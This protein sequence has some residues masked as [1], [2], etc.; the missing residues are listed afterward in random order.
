MNMSFWTTCFDE[1][2]E[3]M[4]M[5]DCIPYNIYAEDDDPLK[6]EYFDEDYDPDNPFLDDDY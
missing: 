5:N 3:A 4:A 1:L 2:F 6:Y